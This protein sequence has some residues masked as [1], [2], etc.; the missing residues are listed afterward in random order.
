MS[1]L[2]RIVYRCPIVL[3]AF[4]P[5]SLLVDGGIPN[6]GWLLA[7]EGR[8]MNRPL[9]GRLVVAVVVGLSEAPLGAGVLFA[10]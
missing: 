5:S 10:C 1:A 2:E 9:A 7:D 6:D 4:S 8:R 3:L